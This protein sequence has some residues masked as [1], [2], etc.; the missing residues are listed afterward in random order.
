MYRDL[1]PENA[2]IDANGY[3]HLIDLGTAKQLT[4]ESE[5]GLRTF[6]I[7]GTYFFTQELLI[8]WLLRSSK[9]RDTLSPSMSGAWV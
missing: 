1:K 6:T 7:I 4:E 2:A 3:L 8:T 5:A 9:P